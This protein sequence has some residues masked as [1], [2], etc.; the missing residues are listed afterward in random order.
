MDPDPTQRELVRTRFRIEAVET[1]EELLEA[2]PSAAVVASP[3]HLHVQ[4]SIQ[5]AMAGCDLFIEKPLSYSLDG[6]A[7]L[8]ET[9]RRAE[10]TSMV[11]CNMRFHPGPAKVK[12]LLEKKEI[13]EVLA[14]RIQTGS[15]LPRWRSEGDYHLSYSASKQWGGAILDCIHEIDLALW[16]LGPAEMLSAVYLPATSIGLETDGLAEILLRHASGALSSVHLNFVQRDYRRACQIIGTEGSLYWDFLGREINH[17]NHYGELS[18]TIPEPANWEMNQMYL[19]EIKHFL[20]AVQ[21]RSKTENTLVEAFESL[22][23]AV[24]ARQLKNR[25]VQ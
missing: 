2:G 11:G 16:Y 25:T 24:S 15:Y 13:G 4:Q 22:K 17:Y 6:V 12:A 21:N 10:V 14:A 3:S 18:Q 19:D 20:S 7:D 5:L 8:L 9:A 1:M 23:I